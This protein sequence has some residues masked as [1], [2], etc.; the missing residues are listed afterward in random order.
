MKRSEFVKFRA[1]VR[2]YQGNF[3]KHNRMIVQSDDS[4]IIIAGLGRISMISFGD[5][6]DGRIECKLWRPDGLW[7]N[8]RFYDSCWEANSRLAQWIADEK[9]EAL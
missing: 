1:H 9:E 8:Q 4:M 2:Q 3:W 7:V 6:E 5:C